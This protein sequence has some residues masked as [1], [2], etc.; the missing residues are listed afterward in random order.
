MKLSIAASLL[1][2]A[3]VIAYT[4]NNFNRKAYLNK[5]SPSALRYVDPSAED[6]AEVFGLAEVDLT[7]ALSTKE[8]P[9]TA[10]LAASLGVS[11]DDVRFEYD[12]WLVRYNKPAD[13][14]RYPTFKKNIL[15]QAQYN[16]EHG[17]G[18]NFPLNEYG[19]LTEGTC[20]T[21]IWFGS[22]LY[23][24]SADERPYFDFHRGI[25][26]TQGQRRSRRCA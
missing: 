14:T 3:P 21:I 6:E 22:Y 25:P 15:L 24:L 11:D 23:H 13:E 8:D 10:A 20:R 12:N 5:P 18:Q 16:R 17:H 4:T 1:L 9:V 7:S 26:P 19:D 2:S